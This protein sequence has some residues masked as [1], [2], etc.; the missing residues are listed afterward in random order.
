MVRDT[1]QSGTANRI[2]LN[3]SSSAWRRFTDGIKQAQ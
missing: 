1:T 3:M 2:V